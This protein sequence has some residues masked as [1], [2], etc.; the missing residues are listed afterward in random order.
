MARKLPR[1]I[2]LNETIEDREAWVRNLHA[3][4]LEIIQP[5]LDPEEVRPL[6]RSRIGLSVEEREARRA[7][8]LLKEEKMKEIHEFRQ[9][10]KG[11][12]YLPVERCGWGSMCTSWECPMTLE[13][14]NHE[15]GEDCILDPKEVWNLPPAMIIL[16]PV[17][18]KAYMDAEAA[19]AKATKENP[20]WSLDK[21]W[22][23]ADRRCPNLSRHARGEAC[24]LRMKEMLPLTSNPPTSEAA[25]T[26][27]RAVAAGWRDS[28]MKPY[29]GLYCIEY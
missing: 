17:A 3:R 11:P 27:A 12:T 16:K 24:K 4:F 22:I 20:D 21:D 8:E 14:F 1:P 13:A 25:A 5:L 6:P 28:G 29:T 9:N 26:I 2:I 10:Y 23:C 18:A 19:L 15:A 7:Y